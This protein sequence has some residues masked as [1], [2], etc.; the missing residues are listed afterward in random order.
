MQFTF[1]N[2]QMGNYLQTKRVMV[3]KMGFTVFKNSK[4]HFFPSYHDFFKKF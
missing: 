1:Y 3:L 2:E 4:N